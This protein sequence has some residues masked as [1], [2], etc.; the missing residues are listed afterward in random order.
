M[1][2]DRRAMGRVY[3]MRRVYT[4]R[5][6]PPKRP[7]PTD[8]QRLESLFQ[9]C[10]ASG[11]WLWGGAINPRGYGVFRFRGKAFLAHRAS[12]ILHGRPVDDR[13]LVCHRCDTRCCVNPAHLFLG[14]ATENSRDMAAKGRS[15][16]GRTMAVPA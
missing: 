8:L 14:T 12:F 5:P 13:K 2:F 7:I 3:A 11:C 15:T 1:T 4:R 16:R 9:P 10:T 6:Q